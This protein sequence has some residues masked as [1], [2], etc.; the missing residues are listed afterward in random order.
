MKR[1]W[2]ENEKQEE[3]LN[4]LEGIKSRLVDYDWD[5]RLS[6]FQE[7]LNNEMEDISTVIKDMQ[8]TK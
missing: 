2:G 1:T 8:S 5:Y 6:R 3:L 7:K 4:D